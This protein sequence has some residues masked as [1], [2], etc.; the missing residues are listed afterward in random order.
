[1][2]N[3]NDAIKHVPIAAKRLM[4]YFVVLLTS[5][6]FSSIVFKLWQ[7]TSD[8]W[9]GFEVTLSFLPSIPPSSLPW[10]PTASSS[11][12]WSPGAAPSVAASLPLW[13]DI[14]VDGGDLQCH[15]NTMSSIMSNQQIRQISVWDR[16]KQVDSHHVH[17]GEFLGIDSSY[18]CQILVEHIN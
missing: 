5:A 14:P 16:S 7:F 11:S 3:F 8:D 4:D 6:H 18:R 2:H 1:M 13:V 9:S 17:L 10:I 12:T 15:G